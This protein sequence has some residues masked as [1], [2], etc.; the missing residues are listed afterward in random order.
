M[1]KMFR[2][3]SVVALAPMAGACTIVHVEGADPRTIVRAGILR[4]ATADG[5]RMVAYRS[6]GLGLVPGR[7]GAT[8]GWSSERAAIVYDRDACR[9]VILELPDSGAAAQ[10]WRDLLAAHPDICAPRGGTAK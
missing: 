7:N 8:L 10:R 2:T 5:A 6:H 3:A 1:N 9:V 4:L